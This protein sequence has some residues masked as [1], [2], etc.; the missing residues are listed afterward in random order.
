[1]PCGRFA[2]AVSE[3]WFIASVC[4]QWT[5]QIH[6]LFITALSD[7]PR[8]GPTTLS[9]NCRI[10][11][12]LYETIPCCVFM[13]FR[14]FGGHSQ[15]L[16]IWFIADRS[17]AQVRLAVPDREMEPCGVS[18]R[19]SRHARL[20]EDRSANRS[21]RIYNSESMRRSCRT[22]RL[23]SNQVCCADWARLGCCD[24]LEICALPPRAGD[25]T[26]S[27]RA[28]PHKVT[29]PYGAFPSVCL[30][31]IPLQ[32]QYTSRFRRLWNGPPNSG[33]NCTLRTQG[34]QMKSNNMYDPW[35]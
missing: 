17:L 14:T 20:W 6:R 28:L 18:S 5:P 12:T 1:M 13:D 9:T 16:I 23:A 26:S 27:V 15:L 2:N 33:T 32:R 10:A 34:Q 8:I 30:S 31:R 24:S 3:T 22:A 11:I 4:G 25:R 19:R 21:E 29:V 7:C 35:H